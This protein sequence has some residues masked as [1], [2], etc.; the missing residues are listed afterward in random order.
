MARVA[1]GAF[2]F[3][4]FSHTFDGPNLYGA[5]SF[6]ETIPSSP[7][8][9]IVIMLQLTDF[10]TLSPAQMIKR[11]QRGANLLTDFRSRI[12]VLNSINQRAVFGT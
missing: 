1:A 5:S 7:S 11:I 12:D 10:R 6:F 2:G 9:Q 3:L 4:I 8:W